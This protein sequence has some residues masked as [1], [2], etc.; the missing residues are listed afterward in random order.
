[1][2]GCPCPSCLHFP[3]GFESPGTQPCGLPSVAWQTGARPATLAADSSHPLDYLQLHAQD[4]V[5]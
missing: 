5:T 4:I 1:M 2:K 3:A